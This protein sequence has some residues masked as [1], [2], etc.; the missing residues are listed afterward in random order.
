MRVMGIDPGTQITGYG[1]VEKDGALLRH[2]DNGCLTARRGDVLALR[3]GAIYGTLLEKLEQFRPDVVAVEEIFFSKN[4]S[5]ALRVGEGRGIVLLAAVQKDIPIVEY[6]TREVKQAMTGYGQAS[7]EQ[8]QQMVRRILKLPEVAQMDAS[9]AL[10]LAICHLN[11][12]QL[13]K[14]VG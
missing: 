9:D 6:S 1:V 5:S 11:S 12:F 4:I 10:A 13:R 14:V 2:I 7:K 8:V 3:L